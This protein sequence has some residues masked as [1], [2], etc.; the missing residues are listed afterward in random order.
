MSGVGV[1]VGKKTEIWSHPQTT[2]TQCAL[3][4]F[5]FKVNG[6]VGFMTA[7]GPAM[8]GGWR[9]KRCFVLNQHQWTPLRNMIN[10][11]YAASAIEVNKDQTLI[12]GGYGGSK[13]TELISSTGTE[14]GK[15][16]PVIITDHC[17]LKINSTHGLIT[18]G[19]QDG[20]I[21]VSTWYVELT[22]LT[23]TPGPEMNVKRD[24]HGC[25]AFHMGNKTYGIASG[26][27]NGNN[28]LDST[29]IIDLEKYTPTWSEGLQ[30]I[31]KIF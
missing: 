15:D 9:E 24:G 8:C 4:D 31:S 13:T 7:L 16:F 29:E 28:D 17:T 1:G 3:P 27:Y 5:P 25:A 6:A 23:F 19:K 26:G 30:D 10:E 11:R 21:S 12:I 20:S 2:K 14:E 22:K 18:G